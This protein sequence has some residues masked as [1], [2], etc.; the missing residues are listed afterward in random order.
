MVLLINCFTKKYHF[1]VYFNENKIFLGLFSSCDCQWCHYSSWHAKRWNSKSRLIFFK[2]V[3]QLCFILKSI[4]RSHHRQ[5]LLKVLHANM[6]IW[7]IFWMQKVWWN[8][9]FFFRKKKHF[10]KKK[11]IQLSMQVRKR[12]QKL[13]E[14]QKIRCWPTRQCVMRIKFVF[15]IIIWKKKLK[16]LFYFRVCWRHVCAPTI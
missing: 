5:S 16:F 12:L 13:F 11:K 6:S 14:N 10:Q 1:F 8:N 4:I 15:I 9:Y 2:N 7:N 3:F